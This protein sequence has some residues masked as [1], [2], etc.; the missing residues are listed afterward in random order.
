MGHP[1]A[2]AELDLPGFVP[3]K[4]SQAEILVSY[5]G[6]SLFVLLAVWLVSGTTTLYAHVYVEIS[7][8]LVP[9]LPLLGFPSSLFELKFKFQY[10]KLEVGFT[11]SY[12]GG[13][14][15]DVQYSKTQDWRDWAQFLILN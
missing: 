1:Y 5:L 4:L 10:P 7:L 13:K 15:R 9:P 6:A 11:G 8:L 14:F 2:P 12:S 3:L